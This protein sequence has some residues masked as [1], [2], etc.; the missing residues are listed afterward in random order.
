[1]RRRCYEAFATILPILGD[2]ALQGSLNNI[3]KNQEKKIVCNVFHE[4]GKG[5]KIHGE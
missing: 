1:V 2:K 4:P 3:D 5:K